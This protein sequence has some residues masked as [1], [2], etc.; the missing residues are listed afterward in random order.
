MRAQRGVQLGVEDG[1]AA[2]QGLHGQG[3]GEIRGAHQLVEV[4]EGQQQHAEHAVGAV[5]E[6]EALLLLEQ[7]RRDPGLGQQLRHRALGALPV[8]GAP[9]PHEHD[10]AVGERGEIP[11]AAQRAVLV[12][13]RGDVGVQQREHR[14]DHD[15][16]HPGAA[17]GEGAGAQQHEG[18]HHLGLHLGPGAGGV[19]ADQGA[20]QGV[21]HARRDR[22]VGERTESGGDAVDGGV[23][24][25]EGVDVGAHGGDLLARGGVE[26]HQGAAAGDGED[27]R[28]GETAGGQGDGGR[29]GGTGHRGPF[30]ER[31]RA[32]RGRGCGPRAVTAAGARAAR[33]AGS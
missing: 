11:G 23:P 15:G 32:V 3:G 4:G 5:D 7:H 16:S 20:L 17:G 26:L 33:R 9:L 28:G 2:A 27:V 13:D 31:A 24:G 19:G 8:A 18:A 6:R 29:G 14:L 25:G 10:R 30:G 12:D 21:A 22:R 1:V